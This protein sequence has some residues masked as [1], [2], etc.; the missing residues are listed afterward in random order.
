MSEK[1]ASNALLTGIEHIVKE[2]IKKAPIDKT[3]TAVVKT[4]KDE[5]LYDVFM[6]G[7]LYPNVPSIFTNLKI[8]DTIKV[9][10]PQNQYSSMYI[11]GKFNMDNV[12]EDIGEIKKET[13]PTVPLWAKEPNKPSY[14]AE[15]VGALSKDTKIPIKTSDLTND[16][17][18]LTQHQDIS[19]KLDKNQGANNNGKILGINENGDIIPIVKPSGGGS[20]GTSDYTQ[21]INKPKINGNE[22]NGNQTAE[23]L[24]LQPKGDYALKSDLNNK[25]DK[26]QGIENKG[27]ILEIND[28][29]D[30]IPVLKSLD[31]TNIDFSLDW[32]NMEEIPSKSD[33]NTYIKIG[34]YRGFIAGLKNAPDMGRLTY[35]GLGFLKVM[36]SGVL[37]QIYYA[38]EYTGQKP[39]TKIRMFIRSGQKQEG[40][41][42][43][44]EKWHEVYTGGEPVTVYQGIGN[45]NKIL[46]TNSEGN[47][48]CIDKSSISGSY[49]LP[50][51][52]INTL[53]G[54]KAEE[55]GIEDTV[56]VKIDGDGKLYVPTYPQNS[57]ISDYTRLTNKPSINGHEL[58]GNLTTKQ[59]GVDIP[60]KLPNPNTLTFTGGAT[61]SY[62][63]SQP[64]TVNIPVSS[65][66]DSS[67]INELSFK[68]SDLGLDENKKTE[69][70]RIRISS[71]TPEI[72]DNIN[73]IIS[74]DGNIN[75]SFGKE[76]YKLKKLSYLTWGIILNEYIENYT[77]RAGFFLKF[78]TDNQYL[79][80]IPDL[81]HAN[82]NTWGFVKPIDASLPQEWN[83]PVGV[84]KNGRLNTRLSKLTFTGGVN[85]VYDGS[86]SLTIDIPVSGGTAD[87][88]AIVQEVLRAL[89]TWDGGNY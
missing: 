14:T 70:Q 27:K 69:E 43:E 55:K 80:W 78:L 58:N 63:G 68:A 83:I 24:G 17:G 46:A 51:A 65:G 73:A 6:Q 11:E 62:D 19:G 57:E 76:T 7:Q 44:W 40:N 15:E 29:G 86:K 52:N 20:S 84:D 39:P 10:I 26:N 74:F 81:R 34:N 45:K 56:P 47:I 48:V 41:S 30:I 66:G 49:K 77:Q 85:G 71:Q 8:N 54:V 82:N 64:L 50:I 67:G 13:D 89:P 79:S 88:Q 5:N 33:L 53:G 9:K 60:T 16:S 18:F 32:E 35:D 12:S 23:Q 4:V 22:L 1:Q 38:V 21:L 75:I 72:K 42:C 36:G 3:Y 37:I 25:L 2:E 87:T 28:N 61:G 59:I 31:N